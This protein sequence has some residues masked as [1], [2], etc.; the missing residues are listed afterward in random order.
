MLSPLAGFENQLNELTTLS[1][2]L[3]GSVAD[4]PQLTQ[5]E[6]ELFIG[7]ILNLQAEYVDIL[8]AT[9]RNYVLL[10]LPTGFL[11]AKGLGAISDSS[12]LQTVGGIFLGSIASFFGAGMIAKS[13]LEE[14]A[15]KHFALLKLESKTPS[16]KEI[17]DRLYAILDIL[18]EDEAI[19][20]AEATKYREKLI[21]N[22]FSIIPKIG[23]VG[24]AQLLGSIANAN[25]GYRRNDNSLLAGLGWFFFGSGLTGTGVALAEGYAKPIK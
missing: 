24:L 15:K 20:E 5:E 17:E 4:A 14:N 19:T 13:Q 10:Q 3:I 9:I 12:T 21:S 7:E 18:E 2:T 1:G 8:S 23:A 22:V 16:T 6:K 11:A 25:H